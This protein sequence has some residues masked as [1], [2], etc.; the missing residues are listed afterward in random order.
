[1]LPFLQS[2]SGVLFYALGLSFFVSYLLL[3]NS[4]LSE[5]TEWWMRTLDLPLILSALLYGGLSLLQGLQGSTTK[6]RGL[7]FIIFLPIAALFFS[8]MI[9]NFWGLEL[10]L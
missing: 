1:M 2:L 3:K 9:L 10:A 8:F 5:I 7:T 4:I 6:F